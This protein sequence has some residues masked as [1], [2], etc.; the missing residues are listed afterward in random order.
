MIVGEQKSL[1]EIS[2]ITGDAKK[3]LI[4]GCGTCVTISYAGGAKEVSELAQVMRLS[5]SRYK[6]KIDV[7]EPTPL[8]Q[9]ELE[10]IDEIQ[11]DV[12]WADVVISLACGVGVQTMAERF[13]GSKIMPGVNTIM[14]G[15]HGADRVFKEYCGA[16]GDCILHETGGICPV[17]R[18]SK[19]MMNGP[20]GG[21]VSGKCEV[22][23]DIDCAWQLI[24]DRLNELK[25]SDAMGKESSK[26]WSKSWHGG[27]RIIDKSLKKEEGE[28]KGS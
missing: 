17:V 21:S 5:A 14:M 18:C 7:R 26:D 9:C 28:E 2:A 25:Q 27:P 15:S 23:E 13:P 4:A 3:I 16:C 10:F 22:S 19:S 24:F 20:C 6:K 1:E 8:R 12:K 11:E